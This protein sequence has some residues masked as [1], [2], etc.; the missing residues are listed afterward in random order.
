MCHPCPSPLLQCLSQSSQQHSCFS[1][2]IST[3]LGAKCALASVHSIFCFPSIPKEIFMAP[4]TKVL[5][6]AQTIIILKKQS[7]KDGEWGGYFSKAVTF[8]ITLNYYNDT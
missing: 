4:H 7:S 5:M 3:F 1:L 2:F 6:T 8:E